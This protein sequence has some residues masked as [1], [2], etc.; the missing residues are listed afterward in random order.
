MTIHLTLKYEGF[1]M[2]NRK[3]T[4]TKHL[5]AGASVAALSVFM[6]QGAFADTT[7][8]STA[9]ATITAGNDITF[10]GDYVGT[11]TDGDAVGTGGAVVLGTTTDGVGTLKF[12]GSSVAT[13]TIGAASHSIKVLEAAGASGKT[14]SISGNVYA[15]TTTV[16]GAGALAFAGNLTG[17]TLNFTADG[18]V[19]LANGKTLAAAVTTKTT[20]TGTLTFAQG[21]TMTGNI[22]TSTAKLKLVTVSGTTAGTVAASGDIYATTVNFA[23]NGTLTIADGKTLSAAVTTTTT[24]E[25]TVEFAG[26]ATVSGDLGEVDDNILAA[27]TIGSGDVAAQ[28]NIA[29]VDV[30]FADDGS[31]TIANGKTLQA[32]VTT[33]TDE[34]GTLTF[35]QDATVE[36]DIGEDGTALKLIT[37]NAGAVTST[38]S[39]YAT[40]VNFVEDGSLKIADGETLQAAVT[41][42]MDGDGT[43]TFAGAATVEGDIGEDG[44]AL[45]LITVNAGAVT[46]TGNIAATTVNFAGDG[47]LQIA[48]S[49]TLAGDV[50]TS[51]NNTGTLTFAG[52]GTM[53]G[54]V[55]AS[56]AK[57]KLVT[58]GNGAVTAS[59]DIYATTVN[60]AG[61]NSLTL[62]D[63]ADVTGNITAT[64]GGHGTLVFEG[65][66]VINGSV[67][68]TGTRISKIDINSAAATD[69]VEFTGDVFAASYDAS[70][71]TSAAT[72]LIDQGKTLTSTAA[73]TADNAGDGVVYKFGVKEV[74]G[75]T[76]LV[77][78]LASGGAV[79]LTNSK[80]ALVIDSASGFIAAG[81]YYKVVDGT[82]AATLPD[83]EDITED[84]YLL[85][86]TAVRGDDD[87][88][89]GGDSSEIYALAAVDHSIGSVSSSANINALGTALQA[90]AT[91]GDSNSQTLLGML[92]GSDYSTASEVASALQ[93]LAPD[94]S[95]AATN[96]AF[97]ASNASIHTVSNRM[98]VARAEMGGQ[99]IAAGSASLQNGA[100][101][102]VFG[103]NQ[104]Q[105]T[106]DGVNG[107]QADT[108]GLAVG[109]ETAINDQTRA[110]L[111]FAYGKTDADS[112]N[113]STDIDSYQASI[114]GTYAMDNWYTDAVA[115]YTYN[116]Y[117]T[118]RTLFDTS[119]A[120]ADFNGNQYDIR[121]TF[122]YNLGETG[123]I[124]ITPFAGLAYTYLDVD[125]YTETGSNANL[126]VKNSSV[127]VLKSDLGA[128]F[129][130]PMSSNGVTYN[131]HVLAAWDYDFIGDQTKTTSNF[132]SVAGVT[133]TSKGADVARNTIRLGAGL[134]VMTQ[135][136][137]TVSLDYDYEGRTKFDS[138]AGTVK[139]RFG[140]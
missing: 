121:G 138:H 126:H 101:G 125:D 79:D 92:Q 28:G 36:G 66:S 88:I 91:G 90:A 133:F 11:V 86:F 76:D 105:D 81:N 140:F 3:K 74:N 77:G 38:G 124:K 20:N 129:D 18:S 85:S 116:D 72:V 82:G 41:T 120:N 40:T 44:T 103:Q 108:A 42:D 34:T 109:F 23:H 62:A 48:A 47:S 52:A 63:N 49:N 1:I 98:E 10:S 113:A 137:M 6:G 2:T 131:P 115:S 50:T 58:V 13:G 53:T 7:T 25:G 64:T 55:G 84:S 68:V 26:D 89:T 35:A 12:A 111:A 122:G 73:I 100:W 119:V 59:D 135:D 15:T 75:G 123:G 29:A 17:T 104:D 16:S 24:E 33:E 99:G 71:A 30:H 87:A 102:Q 43:L 22:G 32:A 95:G 61:N 60:F 139:A 110:G 96:A 107:Y 118:K 80:I 31:L 51:K 134:D 69:V 9:D 128:K 19:S 83:A 46:S 5:L 8:I 70:G 56:G 67:G 21:A 27:V 130:Y 114:Y 37:V 78:K 65:S 132:S 136:N 54:M 106:K 4:F 93:T 127:D 14:V 94:V 57:L 39:I 117:N 45:K 97:S 112:L